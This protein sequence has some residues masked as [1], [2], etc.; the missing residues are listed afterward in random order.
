MKGNKYCHI[1]K[2]FDNTSEYSKKNTERLYVFFRN[3]R[4]VC[5]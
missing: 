4:S 5:N 1:N 2:L 3:K